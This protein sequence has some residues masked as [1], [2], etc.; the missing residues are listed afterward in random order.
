MIVSEIQVLHRTNF[1]AKISQ[2]K[3][4]K[5]HLRRYKLLPIISQIISAM[6]LKVWWET[7]I[8]GYST[9]NDN[10][11]YCHT[12]GP[13]KFISQEKKTE[14]V[15]RWDY[16]SREDTVMNCLKGKKIHFRLIITYYKAQFFLAALN[17]TPHNTSLSHKSLHTP[18]TIVSVPVF[19]LSLWETTR[20]R[21]N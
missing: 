7:V 2:L 16:R 4:S 9:C 5:G 8:R 21:V 13:M 1:R 3:S 15:A 20:S 17:L 14:Y 10:A 19:L 12:R 11:V 18:N 6:H